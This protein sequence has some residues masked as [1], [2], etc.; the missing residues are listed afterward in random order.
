MEVLSTLSR[1]MDKVPDGLRQEDLDTLANDESLPQ[2]LRDAYAALR[3]KPELFAKLN[4]DGDTASASHQDIREGFKDPAFVEYSREKSEAYTQ[5]YIPSDAEEGDT[6]LRPM[7]ESD[8]ARELYL[9]ADSLPDNIDQAALQ[10]IV[11]GQTNG[12]CPP[13]LQAAAKYMLDHPESFQKLAPEGSVSRGGLENNAAPLINLREKEISAFDTLQSNKDTFLRDGDITRESLTALAADESVSAEV[14]EAAKTLLESPTMFGMLDN[15]NKG[16]EPQDGVLKRN[17]NAVHD[18]KIGSSDIDALAGKLT[19]TNR[20][21][22]PPPP[23]PVTPAPGT[24]GADTPAADSSS[25]SSAAQMLFMQ[26]MLDGRD[27]D[28]E[29]KES[30]GGKGGLARVLG[31]MAKVLDAV[32]TGLDVVASFLPPPF[33]AAVAAIS[34]SVGAVNNFGVKAGMA[35]ANG[36]PRREAMKQ[37][38]KDFAWDVATSAASAIPAGGVAVK[39]ALMA[40]K[41]VATTA[42]REG[43]ERV[44]REGV[45]TGVKKAADTG[46]DMAVKRTASTG[47]G[48]AKTGDEV[49]ETAA[50]E[51]GEAG[52][53]Q[54]SKEGFKQTVKEGAKEQLETVKEEIVM[55]VQTIVSEKTGFEVGA[56]SNTEE[57]GESGSSSRKRRGRGASDD[58][59]EKTPPADRTE[60][61][62]RA[63]SDGNDGERGSGRSDN[64]DKAGKAPET[65][66]ER[67]ARR[68]EEAARR[69]E[70]AAQRDEQAVAEPAAT[71][72][73]DGPT[74]VPLAMWLRLPEEPKIKLDVPNIKG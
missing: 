42:A 40:A 14:R 29:I 7:T 36:V 64:G 15:A 58:G 38:A 31:V 65:K 72:Q 70:L 8:A 71:E 10:Q 33:S 41:Q 20:T 28:P 51:G 62:T 73:P 61:D 12:K 18:G 59:S 74:V 45:E 22:P 52:V 46:G 27:D 67:E 34:T 13:Q 9:Y 3:D 16:H 55:H 44:V 4:T 48:A 66:A 47:T 37:A 50:K 54:G 56:P 26:N 6:A 63:K 23:A 32:K 60:R 25:A 30:R 1:H 39:G 57:G 68:E 69:E 17:R 21:P 35:M 53:K 43:A 19:Q 2:D 5:N 11:D 49:V 24:P